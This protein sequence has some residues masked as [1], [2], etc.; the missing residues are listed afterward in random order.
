MASATSLFFDS[1][2][3]LSSIHS[4]RSATHGALCSCRRARRSCAGRPLMVR[5]MSKISSIRRTASTASGEMRG[6]FLRALLELG[7]DIGQFE[8]ITA[9]VAPAQSADGNH[10]I[11]SRWP[12]I[13]P[14]LQAP[15]GKLRRALA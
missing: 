12:D 15:F 4:S 11:Y 13:L 10:P 1:F 8:E 2:D 5:S 14:A 9:R 3:W 6:A 7:G